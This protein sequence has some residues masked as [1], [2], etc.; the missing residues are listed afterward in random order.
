MPMGGPEALLGGGF[1]PLLVP[2]GSGNP[3]RLHGGG[4]APGGNQIHVRWMDDEGA[5]SQ[6][7]PS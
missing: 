2:Q 1:R 6:S 4:P 7:H 3:D 5:V